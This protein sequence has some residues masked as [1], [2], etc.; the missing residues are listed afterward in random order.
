MTN[1][2]QQGFTLA[3]IGIVTAAN[4]STYQDYVKNLPKTKTCQ[5]FPD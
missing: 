1:L 4:I 2:Q 3:I 5:P